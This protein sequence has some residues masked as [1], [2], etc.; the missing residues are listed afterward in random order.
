MEV[1]GCFMR[2]LKVVGLHGMLLI[3][4]ILACF[5]APLAAADS[6]VFDDAFD[7]VVIPAETPTATDA[8]GEA[9][10]D[11]GGDDLDNAFEGMDFPDDETPAEAMVDAAPAA[12]PVMLKA[13]NFADDKWLAV[14]DGISL[15]FDRIPDPA[16]GFLKVFVD[17]IDMSALFRIRGEADL[18]YPGGVVALSPGAHELI[19]YLA[20][21]PEDWQELARRPLRVLTGSGFEQAEIAPRLDVSVNTRNHFSFEKDAPRPR[22]RTFKDTEIQAGLVTR[23][24]RGDLVI[25]TSINLSGFSNRQQALRFGEL[26]GRAPK[27]DMNDY[28]IDVQKG[29]SR[30]QLGHISYGGNPLLINNVASRGLVL[31]HRF[32]DR[33]DASFN[34]MNATSIVGFNNFFGLRDLGKHNITAGTVGLEFIKDRPG[35]LRAEVSY[36]TAS[37]RNETNFN[38]GEV[39]DAEQSDG[40]GVTLSGST[41]GGRLRGSVL[42]ARSNYVNPADPVIDPNGNALP[43]KREADSAY[44]TDVAYDLL[45]QYSPAEG[46]QVSLTLGYRR[47]QADALYRSIGAFVTPDVVK[48]QYSLSASINSVSLQYVYVDT[49]DNVDNIPTLLRTKTYTR[50]MNLNVPLGTIFRPPGLVQYLIPNATYSVNEVRQ[51]AGNNPTG[52]LSGF[53]GGSHLPKQFNRDQRLGLNWSGPRWSA[54]YTYSNSWQDNQQV[55]RTLNDFRNFG[56][57]FSISINPLDRLNLNVSYSMVDNKDIAAGNVSHTNTVNTGLDWRFLENWSLNANFTHTRQD[58]DLSIA[59]RMD[60]NGQAQLNW[61]FAL[62]SIGERKIP[63]S[64]FV[65]YTFQE[66]ESLDNSFGFSSSARTWSVNSGLSISLF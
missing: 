57:D 34:T 8:Q 7:D 21:G 10:P 16:E 52:A 1:T 49:H 38:I 6:A 26:G 58:D 5:A 59:Q 30:L 39:V 37:K 55:G 11:A 50:S 23:H 32:S 24:S 18:V 31:Y 27:Y 36:M 35:G 4:A 2:L 65:R 12:V 46:Y 60:N 41:P 14:S 51:K 45:R 64:L 9:A 17:N 56:N 53:N 25:D 28:L 40:Y 62:P 15:G 42:F 61:S 48:D 3:G 47:D 22:R 63:G 33:L 54:A 20:R 43:V 66:S 19:V 44:S 13:T 29:D